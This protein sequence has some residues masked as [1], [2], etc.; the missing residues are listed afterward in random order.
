MSRSVRRD[1]TITLL[2]AI[3]TGASSATA[4]A[5]GGLKLRPGHALTVDSA[6]AALGRPQGVAC[7][8]TRVAV[9]DSDNGRIVFFEIADASIAAKST[10]KISEAPYPTRIHFE[11]GGG[12]LVLDGK[13]RRVARLDAN[14]VFLGFVPGTG[15]ASGALVESF[16]VGSDGSIYL[17]DLATMTIVKTDAEGH[18]KR[19]IALPAE[20]RAA[21]DLAVDAAG[22]VFV[23]DPVAARVYAALPGQTAFAP[24]GGRLDEDLE[25]ATS[26]AVDGRGRLLILDQ[27]GGGIVILAPDGSFRGRQ[28][29][30]GWTEGLL[31]YPSAICV[32]AHGGVAVADREN[33]RIA[34]FTLAE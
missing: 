5:S 25:F 22:K 2:C 21:S 12:V 16:A 27:S 10:V 28:S 30:A 29:G 14:G 9:A 8:A 6:G 18:P 15:G 34:I 1:L 32:D 17:L 13:S 7:S 20:C 11:P 31:R 26:L 33:H 23:V 4:V 24:L 19:T 3:V